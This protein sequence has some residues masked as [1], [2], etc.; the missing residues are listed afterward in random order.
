M[1]ESFNLSQ[2]PVTIS[3]VRALH[4][5]STNN[6]DASRTYLA[7]KRVKRQVRPTIDKT[8]RLRISVQSADTSYEYKPTI[9]VPTNGRSASKSDF[10]C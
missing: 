9:D 1:G 8:D 7:K 3:Y 2:V 6:K 5:C 10:F 4:P